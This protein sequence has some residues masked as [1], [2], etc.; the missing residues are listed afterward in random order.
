MS[1]TTSSRFSAGAIVGALIGATVVLLLGVILPPPVQPAS[2]AS[3]SHLRLSAK[4]E[5]ATAP[6]HDPAGPRLVVA[7]CPPDIELP[8]KWP[9]VDEAI[10]ASYTDKGP[11][12]L[13]IPRAI[14]HEYAI[15]YARYLGPLR[16]RALSVLEIGVGCVPIMP[17][18]G[19]SLPFWRAYLPCAHLTWMDYDA[20]CVERVEGHADAV[21]Q[22][23][24][25]SPADLDRVWTKGGPF[26]VVVD[27]GGH[28]A[29]QQITTLRTY[30]PRLPPGGVYVLE[31]LL[32]SFIPGLMDNVPQAHTAHRFLSDVIAH[33][34][35]K[36]VR[37][38]AGDFLPFSDP[39]EGTAEIARL[40]VSIDCFREV[41]V[42]IRN[43]VKVI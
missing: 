19:A 32:T 20:K 41:C 28:S 1:E 35:Q 27:D 34:H 22:G 23:D 36:E 13:N 16:D 12:L 33:M 42:L 21:F 10:A 5:W 8:L 38:A 3:F 29:R 26:E 17:V 11:S 4:A 30:F 43:E 31:D 24:Q 37:R 18:E 40:A 25:S 39:I 15:A 2:T 6:W 9:S 14:S 7:A